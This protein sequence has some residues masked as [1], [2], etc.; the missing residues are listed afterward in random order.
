MTYRALLEA[1]DSR[2]GGLYLGSLESLKGVANRMEGAPKGLTQDS[3]ISGD[4]IVP[5]APVLGDELDREVLARALAVSGGARVWGTRPLA[6]CKDQDSEIQIYL[7][8][9]FNFI[10]V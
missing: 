10:V 9:P 2:V 6:K 4:F 8:A 3:I 5:G 1:P 7:L